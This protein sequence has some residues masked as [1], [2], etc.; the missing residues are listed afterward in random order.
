MAIGFVSYGH[1]SEH[2]LRV[3]YGIAIELCSHLGPY[4]PLYRHIIEQRFGVIDCGRDDGL[5]KR[6][7]GDE[8]EGLQD[9]V[10]VELTEV[11]ASYDHSNEEDEA[12]TVEIYQLNLKERP[13]EHSNDD[14]K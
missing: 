10:G 4:E 14:D 12:E 9:T 11:A 3:S 7:H 8:E 5:V 13:K 1:H 2:K 6:R